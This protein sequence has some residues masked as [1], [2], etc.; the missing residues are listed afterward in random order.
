MDY[1]MFYTL[2]FVIFYIKLIF[3]VTIFF[4]TSN[5]ETIFPVAKVFSHS[6]SNLLELILIS[7]KSSPIYLSAV[8]VWCEKDVF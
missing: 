8:F 2:T 3:W 6:L 1:S 4:T 7:P 5:V